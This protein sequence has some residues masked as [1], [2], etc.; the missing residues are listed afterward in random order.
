MTSTCAPYHLPGGPVVGVHTPHGPPGS[1]VLVG[2]LALPMGG[3]HDRLGGRRSPCAS[4]DAGPAMTVRA[5]DAHHGHGRDDPAQLAARSKL[6]FIFSSF[7]SSTCRMHRP[8]SRTLAIPGSP[9]TT[10]AMNCLCLGT[11]AIFAGQMR[12]SEGRKRC[13]AVPL[14]AGRFSFQPHERLAQ[15]GRD[16]NR[17]ARSSSCAGRRAPKRSP[18]DESRAGRSARAVAY[19][20]VDVESSSGRDSPYSAMRRRR[21][22]RPMGLAEGDLPATQ[23]AAG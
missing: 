20:V 4:V 19:P 14:G 21:R 23:R 7:V 17:S 18:V 6:S 3:V 16:G 8:K 10:Y 12:G 22:P 2:V 1:L 9:T 13:C 5:A 15:A 11:R